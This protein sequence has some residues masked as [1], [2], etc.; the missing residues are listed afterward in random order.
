[1]PKFKTKARPKPKPKKVPLSQP[2][3]VMGAK[4]WPLPPKP[5]AVGKQSTMSSAVARRVATT[6]KSRSS[7]SSS[8]S[9]RSSAPAGV[10][11]G[12]PAPS[13]E[14]SSPP[15]S[16]PGATSAVPTAPKA[17]YTPEQEAKDTLEQEYGPKIAALLRAKGTVQSE[18]TALTGAT[19]GYGNNFDSKLAEIYDKLRAQLQ[20]GYTKTG[21]SYTQAEGAIQGA[22]QTA[23]AAIQGAG[24]AVQGEAAGVAAR[25]GIGAGMGGVQD[26]I[27][28]FLSL[29]GTQN[30]QDQASSMS[31]LATNKAGALE[32]AQGGINAAAG[33]GASAR[34]E[35]VKQVAGQLGG[36][37]LQKLKT[38]GEIQGQ[39]TDLESQRATALRTMVQKIKEAREESAREAAKEE[40]AQAIQQN[41]M[42]IQLAKLGLARDKQSFDQGMDLQN[43]GL[44]AQDTAF[45]NSMAMER[46]GLTQRGQDLTHARGVA[47]LNLQKQK[48]GVSRITNTKTKSSIMGT[49][50]P[51]RTAPKPAAKKALNAMQK[52]QAQQKIT[53][54]VRKNASKGTQE[55]F[56]AVLADNPTLRTAEVALKNTTDKYLKSK[57]ISRKSLEKW[58]RDYYQYT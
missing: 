23:G 31:N 9:A 37:N 56:F 2:R 7:A 26:P 29:A 30:A 28:K 45:D 33:E 53:A 16:A 20:E 47:N 48:A 38:E 1:M 50:I 44:K 19:Q 25:L 27:T 21:S 32:H 3:R 13:Q 11:S 8:G 15:P 17:E 40:F 39:L 42:D 43:F 4:Y 54:S 22:H 51:M 5:M 49:R 6:S 12:G 35:L 55:A 18:H 10:L 52:K 46:L 14:P 24:Q 34:A 57:G 41:T 36:L 58:I